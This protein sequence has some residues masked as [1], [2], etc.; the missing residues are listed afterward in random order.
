MAHLSQDSELRAAV[1]DRAGDPFTL[2]AADVLQKPLAAVAPADRDKMKQIFYALMYGMGAGRLA[3]ALG[4]GVHEAAELRTQVLS[5]YPK[6]RSQEP[7][8]SLVTS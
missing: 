1:C 5:K 8:F 7:M 2:L 4:C 3:A 6:A